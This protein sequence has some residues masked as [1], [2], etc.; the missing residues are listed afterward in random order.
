MSSELSTQPSLPR[1]QPLAAYINVAFH[2]SQLHLDQC[3]HARSD[4]ITANEPA[5]TQRR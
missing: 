2:P 1:E 3:N 4:S 5:N